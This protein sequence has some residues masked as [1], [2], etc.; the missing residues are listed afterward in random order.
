[1]KVVGEVAYR[2]LVKSGRICVV[3]GGKVYD[4]TDFAGKH[5]GGR[6]VLEKHSG[7]DVTQVMKTH[8]SHEHSPAAY[9]ML[10]KYCI[11]ELDSTVSEV[12]S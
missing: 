12:G 11:G 2:S 8:D 1:M 4:V 3:N 7:Q 9:R 5:P 10:D 6:D